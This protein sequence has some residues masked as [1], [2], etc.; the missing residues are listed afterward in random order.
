MKLGDGVELSPP[1]VQ[2]S[3]YE[4]LAV[5]VLYPDPEVLRAKE[6]EERA[7]VE[8]RKLGQLGK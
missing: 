1:S 7:K 6:L 2:N 8:D 4:A 5:I 3:G